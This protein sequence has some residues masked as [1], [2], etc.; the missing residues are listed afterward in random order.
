MPI[1]APVSATAFPSAPDLARRVGIILAS[2]VALIARRFLK[3]P[4]LA[5]FTL[6]LANRINRSAR[7]FQR[8][9]ARLAAGKLPPLRTTRKPGNPSP[10]TDA[11]PDESRP[12]PPG[13]GLPPRPRLPSGRAWLLRALGHEVAAYASQLEYVL[14]EPAVADLLAQV[15]AAARIL[16]P[17]RWILGFI[18][19][20]PRRPRSVV[21]KPRRRKRHRRPP[22]SPGQRIDAI[23][24]RPGPPRPILPWL[25]PKKPA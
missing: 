9:M 13:E 22:L 21:R 17:I 15:P 4:R 6:R 25:L 5:I 18:S 24:A 20:A 19:P 16:H 7:R 3:E 23:L 2:L 12:A 11:V 8:L 14:A 1:Q 10:A